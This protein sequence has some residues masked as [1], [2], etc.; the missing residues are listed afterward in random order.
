MKATGWSWILF[1]VETMGLKPGILSIVGFLFWLT[2]ATPWICGH[3]VVLGELL[4]GIPAVDVEFVVR[5]NL[6]DGISR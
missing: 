6:W 3:F 5:G 1:G 4:E 2:V